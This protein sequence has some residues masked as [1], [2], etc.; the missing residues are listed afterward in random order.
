MNT[1]PAEPE[2]GTVVTWSVMFRLEDS[3]EWNQWSTGWQTPEQAVA[4]AGVLA[5]VQAVEEI[6][7]DRI[8]VSRDRF[9]LHD[10]AAL[11]APAAGLD[12]VARTPGNEQ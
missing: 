9:S 6:R 3:T 2:P 12:V 7:F 5:A 1:T 4:N 8:T 10:L 11:T